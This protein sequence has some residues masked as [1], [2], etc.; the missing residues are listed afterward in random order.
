MLALRFVESAAEEIGVKT[1]EIT[2]ESADAQ[3][4]LSRMNDMLFE[5]RYL[6][7]TPRFEELLNLQ[8]DVAIDPEAN[9]AVKYNLA[10]RI[11]PAFQRII[12]PD[13][14]DLANTSRSTLEII[15]FTPI[16]VDYPDSLPIGSGNECNRNNSR[17]FFT[18]NL[19]FRSTTST[20]TTTIITPEVP[21]P[22]P[23]ECETRPNLDL[24]IVTA[25]IT[26]SGNQVLILANP[27]GTLI[28]V[29]LNPTPS[30]GEHVLIKR[31]D[32]A[33]GNTLV[34]TFEATQPL[35]SITFNRGTYLIYSE[36]LGYW[37]QTLDFLFED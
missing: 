23:C 22:E 16:M 30:D 4:I 25:D 17:R 1:A 8:Q 24:T 14:R 15:T 6:E 9:G 7:L 28:T 29:T 10:L 21:V 36:T 12:S 18:P 33:D 13:L 19:P 11:A 2:L 26:T 35:T 31:V 37:M 3:V 34:G 27:V 5:W 32:S 20:V